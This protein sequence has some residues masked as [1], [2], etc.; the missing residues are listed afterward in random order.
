MI[1]EIQ[2]AKELLSIQDPYYPSINKNIV[3]T[4]RVR[5]INIYRDHVNILIAQGS[6]ASK[7][8]Q[9]AKQAISNK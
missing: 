9:Q 8:S 1:S 7:H 5:G 2:L 4:G 3:D 6:K